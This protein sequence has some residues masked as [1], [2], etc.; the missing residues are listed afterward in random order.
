MTTKPNEKVLGEISQETARE[1]L[2][3]SKAM[4]HCMETTQAVKDAI[5]KAE[6]EVGQ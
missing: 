2:E 6:G 5:T 4:Q 3:A 1:L